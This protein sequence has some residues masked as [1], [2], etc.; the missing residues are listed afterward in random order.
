MPKLSEMASDPRTC[1]C[2]HNDVW[3]LNKSGPCT[4]QQNGDF[5][6]CDHFQILCV[7][8]NGANAALPMK[9]AA[10]PPRRLRIFN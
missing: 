4:R 2:T 1:T 3:H 9:K 10:F 5:C 6:E 8:A 7:P